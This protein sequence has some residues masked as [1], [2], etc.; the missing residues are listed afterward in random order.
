MA[1]KSFSQHFVP[2]LSPGQY[3]NVP[4][5]MSARLV[6]LAGASQDV[7]AFEL[8]GPEWR[9]ERKGKKLTTKARMTLMLSGGRCAYWSSQERVC[10]EEPDWVQVQRH[11]ALRAGCDYWLLTHRFIE[12]HL[13][14]YRNRTSAY[15]LLAQAAGWDSAELENRILLAL[16]VHSRRIDQ[17]ATELETSVARVSAASLRLWRRRLVQL[18]MA[19]TY[20]TSNWVVCRGAHGPQ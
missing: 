7:D 8:G 14:E 3:F 16:D 19:E 9:F 4:T 5:A 6:E 13:V 11:H 18:P 12:E 2:G 10:D 15:Y 20:M 17:L 1:R